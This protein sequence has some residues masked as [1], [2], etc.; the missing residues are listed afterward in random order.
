MDFIPSTGSVRQM[1]IA[2][3]IIVTIF[4]LILALKTKS[5]FA[6]I[7]FGAAAISTIIAYQSIFLPPGERG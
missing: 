7:T 6:W 3:L 5:V 2:A 1:H 4:T